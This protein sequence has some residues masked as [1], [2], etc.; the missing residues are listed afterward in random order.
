MIFRLEKP[1]FEAVFYSPHFDLLVCRESNSKRQA[2]PS[3]DGSTAAA[4][5]RSK[6]DAQQRLL[7]ERE[8]AQIEEALRRS[9]QED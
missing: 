5:Q 3:G 8:K 7:E 2:K 1:W 4:V 6:K 9:L